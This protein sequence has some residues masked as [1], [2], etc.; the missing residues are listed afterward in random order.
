MAAAELGTESP[1]THYT[2]LAD[3]VPPNGDRPTMTTQI[4]FLLGLSALR[5]GL[6]WRA[7]RQLNAPVLI[8]ANALSRWHN[9]SLGL[10]RWTGFESRW[11]ALVHSHPVALDSA[12]FVT[13]H[14]YRGFPWQLDD[15]L[16][17]AASAP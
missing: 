3:H 1:P 9:D 13:A 8:S 2:Q 12:G 11:L 10:R 14:R 17:L 4:E 16:D 5:D 15:Y 7:V 6:L